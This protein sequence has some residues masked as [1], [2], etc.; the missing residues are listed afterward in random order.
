MGQLSQ[1]DKK[2][3]VTREK[4]LEKCKTEL[5]QKENTSKRQQKYCFTL[6]RKIKALMEET[7]SNLTRKSIEDQRN[8]DNEELIKAISR[9]AISGSAAHERRRS[10]MIRTVKPL[11]QLTAALN[12]RGYSLKQ[13]VI[14]PCLRPRNSRTK[15]LVK[16]DN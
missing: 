13:S 9:I 7:D 4:L 12:Q 8:A 14:Y 10:E 15:S 3:I 16:H 6:K 2:E 11:D 5:K 1:D